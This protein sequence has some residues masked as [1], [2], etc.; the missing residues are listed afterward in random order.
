MPLP[1]DPAMR[2]DCLCLSQSHGCHLS[3]LQEGEAQK[4]ELSGL[5]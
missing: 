3:L 2:L 1:V 5:T 4:H